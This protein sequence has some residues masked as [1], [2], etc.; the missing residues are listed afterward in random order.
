MFSSNAASSGGS[1]HHRQGVVEVA[2]VPGEQVHAQGQV[3]EA[4]VEVFGVVSL[5]VQGVPHLQVYHLQ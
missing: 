5:Q 3:V 1:L 2:G 4:A